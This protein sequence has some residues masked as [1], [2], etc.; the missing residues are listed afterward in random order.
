MDR[1][2]RYQGLDISGRKAIPSPSLYLAPDE[3]IFHI[4][5]GCSKEGYTSITL[6]NALN[7]QISIQLYSSQDIPDS[8][9]ILIFA[10]AVMEYSLRKFTYPDD[11]LWAFAGLYNQL[12]PHGSHGYSVEKGRGHSSLPLT[13][14][15]VLASQQN[16]L[17]HSCPT[18]VERCT[19]TKL[20]MEYMGLS[21]MGLSNG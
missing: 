18:S 13:K 14:I 6:L 19:T 15:F 7:H 8:L 10:D 16:I 3:A 17:T 12:R 1:A 21:R 4:T 9:R 20:V 2:V 5:K 11:V